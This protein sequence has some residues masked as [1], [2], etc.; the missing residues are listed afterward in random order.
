MAI[1]TSAKWRRRQRLP[2]SQEAAGAT[3]LARKTRR[4][5]GS[6]LKIVTFQRIT[7]LLRAPESFVLRLCW[8]PDL[9]VDCQLKMSGGDLHTKYQKLAQ[10]YG[11]VRLLV[12]TFRAEALIVAQAVASHCLCVS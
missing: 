7:H 2:R 3:N 4:R 6:T 10:E 5:F 8:T 1:T 11:K 12:M 9:D